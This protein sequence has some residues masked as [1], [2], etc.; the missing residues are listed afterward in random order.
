MFALLSTSMYKNMNHNNVRPEN[1]QSVSV[2]FLMPSSCNKYAV[3]FY[4][5][6]TSKC[7]VTVYDQELTSVEQFLSCKVC[8][9]LC[10]VFLLVDAY[11]NTA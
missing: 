1:G 9:A 10:T 5:L 3:L 8:S 11:S 7:I 2:H 4:G 6:I